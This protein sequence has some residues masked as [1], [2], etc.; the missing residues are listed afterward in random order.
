MWQRFTERARKVVF[1]AQEEA[2]K[3]G[4]EFVSTE[5]LLLGLVREPDSTA[6]LVL[7]KLGISLN[8][9]TS[10]IERQ[11]PR[12]EHKPAQEMTLTPRAKCVID[13]AYEEA[14]KLNNN[15]IGTEHLLLGL[16]REG[17][18]L[19]GRVLDK[20]G[21][22]LGKARQETAVLQ[23][24]ERAEPNASQA[25]DPPGLISP[26]ERVESAYLADRNQSALIVVDMQDT[27]LAPIKEKETVI[28]RAKFLIEIARE[29]RVP[30]LVSEQYAERMGG[31]NAEILES[32]GAKQ[33][34][35]DKLSFSSCGIEAFWKEWTET[36]RNQTVI[37]GIETHICVNQTALDFLASKFQ[38]FVCADAVGSRLSPEMN[39]HALARM[40]DEGAIITHTESIAYEWLG[41][42]GTPEFKKALEIIKRYS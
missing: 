4:H 15:Y 37:A 33:T 5:H 25:E 6:T 40:G 9:I 23:G 26:G 39:S 11:L 29:L 12:S 14:L 34:R 10:E 38:V 31:T 16:I 22:G 2:Q 41:K 28:R 32:L 35:H 8:R 24:Q 27:F 19:A 13:L 18:G 3:L 36:E 20:L 7:Q 42:A 1:Y 21:V 30:I 17:D